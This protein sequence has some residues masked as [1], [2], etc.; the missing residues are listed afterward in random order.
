VVYVGPT[1]PV[2]EARAILDATYLDPVQQGDVHRL[3]AQEPLPEAI[4]I[5]DA[6][7]GTVP[8]VW[9]CELRYAMHR[10]V[11]CYGAGSLGALRAAE[12]AEV[13]M[14]GVGTVYEAFH[15]GRLEDDDEV[16]LAHGGV[17]DGWRPLSAAMVDLRATVAAAVSAGQIDAT[18]ADTIVRAAKARHF[19]ERTWPYSLPRVSVKAEDARAMLARM[20]NDLA[21]GEPW[22]TPAPWEPT[23]AW[24]EAW[25]RDTGTEVRGV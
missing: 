3:L 4:G 2:E 11:R 14:V 15:A 24:A 6:L 20:R 16:A 17:E 7:W 8:T 5:V 23:D 10:G 22:T 9:H 12:L 25:E 21:R 13:G 19:A 1:L 18:R